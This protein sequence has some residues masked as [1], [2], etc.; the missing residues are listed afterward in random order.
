MY[1][2]RE[3][4][5]DYVHLS[6]NKGKSAYCQNYSYTKQ[7]TENGI[8]KIVEFCRLNNY[9]N[10]CTHNCAQVAIGAWNEAFRNDKFSKHILPADLKYEIKNKK[11]SRQ[12]DIITE[13]L[14]NEK[15]SE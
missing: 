14:S 1:F 2:N 7:I 8:N 15:N 9:Y 11:G 12:F 10:L 6:D 3:F 5:Y 13:V 4:A